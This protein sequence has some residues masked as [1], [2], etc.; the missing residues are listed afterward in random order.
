MGCKLYIFQICYENL[1][2]MIFESNFGFEIDRML[3]FSYYIL[4]KL[5]SIGPSIVHT[6]SIIRYLIMFQ[7]GK[8]HEVCFY[9]NVFS[10]DIY[11]KVNFYCLLP[12][13][14]LD[15]SIKCRIWV[16][17]LHNIFLN[18][19]KTEAISIFEGF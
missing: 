2:I 18:C 12:F 5:F 8:I 13:Y 14:L 16:C 19:S 3:S 9:W 15:V 1:A 6:W 17:K 7:H 10:T 4:F 11:R